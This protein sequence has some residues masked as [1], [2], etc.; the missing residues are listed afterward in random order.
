M[1]TYCLHS[2]ES[3]ESGGRSKLDVEEA[4]I[5]AEPEKWL[6]NRSRMKLDFKIIY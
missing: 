3:C 5:G 4:E 2:K 6:N 1:Y